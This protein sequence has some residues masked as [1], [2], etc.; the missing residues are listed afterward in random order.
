MTTKKQ[1][2]KAILKTI[3][4]MSTHKWGQGINYNKK[5]D[6]YCVMGA[7]RMVNGGDP[8]SGAQVLRDEFF[9]VFCSQFCESPTMFNDRN[10]QKKQRVI[11][12]LQKLHD[13]L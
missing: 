10:H 4:F 1:L 7:F 9:D 8:K 13:L 12:K 2:K 3:K 6:S 11:A 5:N